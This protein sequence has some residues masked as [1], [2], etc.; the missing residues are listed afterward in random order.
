VIWGAWPSYPRLS[1]TTTLSAQDLV[2][3]RCAI[4]G[5]LF[6]PVL[7]H[8]A[9]R[10]SP[11]GWREGLTLAFLQDAP[12]AMLVTLGLRFAPAGH[13]AA[14][15]PGLLPLLAASVG[16][17]F[18]NERL[19]STRI[20]GIALMGSVL[21]LWCL[22][23]WVYSRGPPGRAMSCSCALA[24]WAQPMR[25]V[26]ADR[27]FP[28]SRALRSSASI[29][30]CSICRATLW[31]PS[32]SLFAVSPAELL[33]QG[34]QGFLMGAVSL[35]SL[36]RAIVALGATRATAFISLVPVLI[37]VVYSARQLSAK[38]H[39]SSKTPRSSALASACSSRPGLYPFISAAGHPI[40]RAQVLGKKSLGNDRTLYPRGRGAINPNPI[41][42]PFD[43]PRRTT[44][45]PA[46]K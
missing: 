35:F 12:L 5:L 36:S 26:C 31:L 8:G 13:M 15:S 46:T 19:S 17:V 42:P 11:R 23:A 40:R 37:T 1:I 28:H 2:A 7:K 45:I 10:I 6:L 18:L 33:F 16:Y 44:T 3:L 21:S 43:N 25:F 29:R 20:C 41:K 39:R 27:V 34:Y 4:G 38:C 22:S 9:R 24:S 14:L 30:C 32:S